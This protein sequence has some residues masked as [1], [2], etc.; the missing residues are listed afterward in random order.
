MEP[1]AKGGVVA[2][3]PPLVID[4]HGGAAARLVVPC[5]EDTSVRA[6]QLSTVALR[7]SA[8]LQR[9][10]DTCWSFEV[11]PLTGA[12]P[13]TTYGSRALTDAAPLGTPPPAQAAHLHCLRPTTPSGGSVSHL[14]FQLQPRVPTDLP[15]PS[16]RPSDGPPACP[17]PAPAVALRLRGDG[18]T[19]SMPHEPLEMEV[20]T[21]GYDS[22]KHGE[23]IPRPREY[24]LQ[25]GRRLPPLTPSPAR[26]PRGE[27]EEVTFIGLPIPPFKTSGYMNMT[28]GMLSDFD[29]PILF[30][31]SPWSL[32]LHYGRLLSDDNMYAFVTRLGQRTC[33]RMLHRRAAAFGYSVRLVT[34][35]SEERYLYQ[36]GT[37]TVR[38]HQF[39]ISRRLTSDFLFGFDKNIR[40]CLSGVK[41]AHR[42]IDS[43]F[44]SLLASGVAE[45]CARPW[46]A[47]VDYHDVSITVDAE[48]GPSVN[49]GC[50]RFDEAAADADLVALDVEGIHDGEYL[51]VMGVKDKTSGRFD[52][53]MESAPFPTLRGL[54][55]RP[56]CRFLV[57]GEKES[58]WLAEVGIPFDPEQLVDL[59]VRYE[60]P[61][62]SLSGHYAGEW[63]DDHW[64]SPAKSRKLD[65]ALWLLRDAEREPIFVKAGCGDIFFFPNGLNTPSIW[66]ARPIALEHIRYAAGDVIALF[67]LNKEPPAALLYF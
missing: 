60:R 45:L 13:F 59:Q 23:I 30:H 1:L 35:S 24:D 42:I 26:A 4:T 63:P 53:F 55:A 18:A 40:E 20:T 17:S 14:L 9:V 33:L 39:T 48:R 32:D 61:N 54:F 15:L 12:K 29:E 7:I 5:T 10:K 16:E 6:A 62:D 8:S 67:L 38:W 56:T 36:T 3:Q 2:D 31:W 43:H 27:Y 57:W 37:Y 51:A 64:V 11:R 50:R 44:A 46:Q 52:V 49:V 22:E 25:H 65:E 34:G 41:Q 19:T 58:Q 66:S 28:D 47:L 21:I